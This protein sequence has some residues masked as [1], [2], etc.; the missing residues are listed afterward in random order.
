M[1]FWAL[2]RDFFLRLEI[3]SIVQKGHKRKSKE[4]S[5]D[6]PTVYP[7]FWIS[8][9]K[10]SG[11]CA[12]GTWMVTNKLNLKISIPGP[13][14]PAN[15]KSR[16]RIVYKGKTKKG[17]G[18]DSEP[19]SAK[20]TPTKQAAQK[21]ANAKKEVAQKAASTKKEVAKKPPPIKKENAKKSTS[22][23]QTAKLEI[24][25][26]LLVENGQSSSITK[27]R[28]NSKDSSKSITAVSTTKGRNSNK[29]VSKFEV[30]IEN[31]EQ[32]S[33]SGTR[34]KSRDQS[35]EVESK[36]MKKV[37]NSNKAVEQ[38]GGKNE[39]KTEKP[40]SGTRKSSRVKK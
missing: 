23:R 30:K 12:S 37:E 11:F 31:D 5:G 21:S 16:A 29:I 40:E 35:V 1:P 28:R 13:L 9:S 32:I 14:K 15:A 33:R 36:K 25:T 4:V 10:E 34:R 22:S 2:G 18:E 7:V 39:P 6:Y 38:N 3:Y 20:K 26:E 27:S 8:D 17:E 24:K 19:K